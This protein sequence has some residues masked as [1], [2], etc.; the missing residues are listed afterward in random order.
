MKFGFTLLIL[1]NFYSR[2]PQGLAGALQDLGIQFA[3]REHSGTI[4]YSL[5][6]KNR[7]W[8]L[9]DYTF[10]LRCERNYTGNGL[11]RETK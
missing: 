1:Q 9:S 7:F 5:K 8:L 2:K 4:N 6:K 11:I 10:S 3:G